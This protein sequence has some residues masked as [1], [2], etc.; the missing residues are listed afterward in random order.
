[1]EEV[2]G[3][4]NVSM[5]SK[6][7]VMQHF[8]SYIE[9]YNTATM[10]HSKFYNYEQWEMQD[11]Q[12]KQQSQQE[13]RFKSASDHQLLFSNDEQDRNRELKMA[14]QLEEQREFQ[15]LRKRLTQD[16]SLQED[17]K[18]Q[19]QMAL[20]LQQAFKVG[21]KSTVKRL[22]KLLA[23]DVPKVTIKHPWA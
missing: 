3:I 5:M 15:E 10:P 7:E 19:Q 8:K 18:R 2:K 13:D 6:R 1:M 14:K 16:K 9:D 4:P 22:E 12:R 20:E 21:D 23:P 17:M 11:Y